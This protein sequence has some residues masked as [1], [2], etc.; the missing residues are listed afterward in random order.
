MRGK[1][2]R[3]VATHH[4]A[5]KNQFVRSSKGRQTSLSTVSKSE[6]QKLLTCV[7]SGMTPYA[8]A[9]VV[10]RISVGAFYSWMSK[11][12]KGEHPYD[13]F[14]QA[15]EEAQAF[16]RGAAEGQVWT[17]RPLDWLTKGPAGK[18]T[19][20]TLEDGSV[21]PVPGWSEAPPPKSGGEGQVGVFIEFTVTGPKTV[22]PKTINLLPGQKQASAGPETDQEDDRN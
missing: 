2:H 19:V 20:A 15:V 10:L 1:R 3:T 16:A 6:M 7:A 17:D 18:E 14:S 9:L 13:V 8:A 21:T 22:T 12:R 5:K 11:G 4:P